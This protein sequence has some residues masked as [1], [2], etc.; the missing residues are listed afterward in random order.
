MNHPIL[1]RIGSV[2]IYSQ[3]FFLTLA[4]ILGTFLFWRRAKQE[5]F[6]EERILDLAL[7]SLIFGLVGAR[8]VFVLTNFSVFRGDP[9]DILRSFSAG[10]S[11][12][13]GFVFGVLGFVLFAHRVNWSF[14]KLLDLA[15]PALAFSQGV[16]MIGVFLSGSEMAEAVKVVSCFLIFSLLVFLEKR[17]PDLRPA[18]AGSLI[19]LYFSLSGGMQFAAGFFHPSGLVAIPVLDRIFPGLEMVLGVAALGLW[20]SPKVSS[21]LGAQPSD[22]LTL[23][24]SE[25]VRGRGGMKKISEGRAGFL[26]GFKNWAGKFLARVRQ[27]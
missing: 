7:T 14:L 4:V 21:K 5:G 26:G 1:L 9:W 16:G 23:E 11:F 8:L 3:G 19:F 25:A 27:R 13:G 10:L 2:T 20:L 12:P 18:K 17:L 6:D 24:G 15:A 22:Q